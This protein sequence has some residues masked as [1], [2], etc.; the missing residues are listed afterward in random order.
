MSDEK[1]PDYYEILQISQNA[2]PDTINRI[3]RL[4]AQRYHPDNQES[5]DAKKFR[6][7]H[8]AYSVLIDPEKRAQ[9]DVAY[10]QHR[11]DRWRLVS[12]GQKAANDFELETITRLTVLEVLYTQRRVE[13]G[14]VGVYQRELETLTGRASEHIE[15]TI[16]YLIQ[17][18]FI[19]RGDSSRIN[20]TADG[21]DHLEQNYREHGLKRLTEA[22]SAPGR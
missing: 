3:F 8:E 9:Y 13:P 10:Q 17:K 19:S 20:I 4:F 5:G 11:Q 2:E 16:W 7:V 6:T 15:F 12:H 1:T 14:G 22:Q 21:M 18:G